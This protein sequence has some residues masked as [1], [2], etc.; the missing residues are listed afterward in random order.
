MKFSAPGSCTRGKQPDRVT[1]TCGL[2]EGESGV[3]LDQCLVPGVDRAPG[4]ISVSIELQ[5]AF[6]GLLIQFYESN[7]I[8]EIKQFLYENCI[9]GIEFT[10]PLCRSR[11]QRRG[12]SSKQNREKNSEEVL[13]AVHGTSS[14]H[15]LREAVTLP[16]PAAGIC[17]QVG[18]LH[19]KAGIGL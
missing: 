19:V 1:L 15:F 13:W 2:T 5:P 18:V 14:F 9:D 11:R 10:P 4:I 6:I 17:P 8:M 12:E 16:A 3:C 7:D